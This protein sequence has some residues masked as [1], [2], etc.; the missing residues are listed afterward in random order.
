LRCLAPIDVEFLTRVPLAQDE[1][2]GRGE[3][4]ASGGRFWQETKKV[5]SEL[6]TFMAIIEDLV[7]EAGT[8]EEEMTSLLVDQM[9]FS[10]LNHFQQEVLDCRE[11]QI[12]WGTMY[13]KLCKDDR[14]KDWGGGCGVNGW[15]C[16]SQNNN[17]AVNG[18]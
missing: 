18:G 4:Q 9:F 5:L 10:V 16:C 14:F 15:S 12:S 1:S 6:R 7:R 17:L 8:F 3:P 2:S 11:S 13:G